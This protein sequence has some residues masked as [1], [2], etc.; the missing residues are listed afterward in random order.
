MNIIKLKSKIIK[1]EELHNFS[2]NEFNYKYN[3]TNNL[4]YKQ[5]LKHF[6]KKCYEKDLENNIL[7]NKI[8]KN[9]IENHDLKNL[10]IKLDKHGEVNLTSELNENNIYLDCS[11]IEDLFTTISFD[12]NILYNNDF[13][14]V[15]NNV[16]NFII[17]LSIIPSRFI[18]KEFLYTIESLI[19]QVIKPKYIIINICKKYK[20]NF[21]QINQ[22]DMLKRINLI[23]SLSDKIV[24]NYCEDL[25]PITKIVGL[26]NLNLDN[27]NINNNDKVIIIDDDWTY[28]KYMTYY[29]NLCYD[30]YMCD[31]IGIDE[32]ELINWDT[33]Y[34]SC[35]KL[36][37][38][39]NI[40]YDNYQS[41]I[42]G[43]LTFSMKFKFIH[44]LKE[45]Y[46]LSI[47][48]TSDIFYHDDLLIS[49]FLKKYKLNVCGINIIFP[50]VYKDRLDNDNIEA[51]HNMDNVWELRSSLEKYYLDKYDIKYYKNIK[52]SNRTKIINKNNNYDNVNIEIEDKSYS[53]FELLNDVEYPNF[54]LIPDYNYNIIYLNFNYCLLTVTFYNQIE[55]TIDIKFLDQIIKI[56]L[57]KSNN[58]SN[59]KSFLLEVNSKYNI[60]LKPLKLPIKTI[61]NFSQYE[62]KKLTR[63]SFYSLCSFINNM[64]NIKFKFY[65]FDRRI[66]FIK[67]FFSEGML[68]LYLKLNIKS[69]RADLFRYLYLYIH[70]GFYHD[71]K[72][73][74]LNPNIHQYLDEKFFFVNEN[75]DSKA[76]GLIYISRDYRHIVKD[77]LFGKKYNIFNKT[78]YIPGILSNIL[79]SVKG[80]TPFDITGP[81]LVGRIINDNFKLN[82]NINNK[83]YNNFS[84]KDRWQ[85]STINSNKDIIVKTNYFNYYHENNYLQTDHYSILWKEDKIYNQNEYIDKI[86]GIEYIMCINLN[87]TKNEKAVTQ[88]SKINIPYS[89]IYSNEVNI[90]EIIPYKLNDKISNYEINRTL[91]HIKAISELKH[92]DGKYFIVCED[93]FLLDNLIIMNENIKQ[94]IDNAPNFDMLILNNSS[95]KE[96]EYTYNKF[97]ENKDISTSFYIISKNGVDFFTQNISNYSHGNN[98]NILV[99]DFDISKKFIFTHLN[100]FIYKYNFINTEHQ[101]NKI[102]TQNIIIKNL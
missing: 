24:F 67:K 81:K 52:N 58:F 46:N 44:K 21:K 94:I 36:L 29:Y 18:S 102:I 50:N 25:G 86:N 5:A 1:F 38:S 85:K 74:L 98:F 61:Y 6:I 7:E 30:L 69:F 60:I 41:Y 95:T 23:Q 83:M 97:E 70:G 33:K 3:N 42:F 13:N 48:N 43:W 40:F 62:T 101:E 49:M 8:P 19:N 56:K 73:I 26:C 39:V 93:D 75:L 16:N 64:P 32:N 14:V 63:N 47:K 35:M 66:K 82:I 87:K 53:N 96:L 27:Y 68:N 12:K 9:K 80:E 78:R 22:D 79:N 45:F 10:D 34:F 88:L 37:E 71:H 100:T 51:L 4:T 65:D 84:I 11:K 17:S 57:D 89:Y 92:K 76:N 90:E 31:A 55:E 28:N 20:R 59:K 99:S 77:I 91:S 2:F 54:D 72:M 15:N